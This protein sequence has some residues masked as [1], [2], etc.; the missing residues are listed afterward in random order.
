MY[1][2]E[3][4]NVALTD[5]DFPLPGHVTVLTVVYVSLSDDSWTTNVPGS[6]PFCL[7]LKV[8]VPGALAT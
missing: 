2:A 5:V 8:T 1:L 3:E 4:D 7:K 6:V